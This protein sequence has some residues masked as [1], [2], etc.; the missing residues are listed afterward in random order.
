MIHCVFAVT[1]PDVYIY[2]EN[3]SKNSGRVRS[4]VDGRVVIWAINGQTVVMECRTINNPPKAKVYWIWAPS[5]SSQLGAVTL[6]NGLQSQDPS[7]YKIGRGKQ[8]DSIRLEI[9]TIAM[10][11]V[12][13]GAGVYTCQSSFSGRSDPIK[14]IRTIEVYELPQ[15][16]LYESSYETDSTEND[17]ITL[18][19]KAIGTPKPEIYWRRTSGTSR[20]ISGYGTEVRGS[21]ILFP[22]VKPSD[23]GLYTCNAI[24]K[25]GFTTWEIKLNVKFQPKVFNVPQKD[26]TAGI[27]HQ[28]IGCNAEIQFKIEG[29]PAPELVT[30]TNSKGQTL[31]N[32]DPQNSHITIY[33]L[34][35]ADSTVY[36]SINFQ[37]FTEHDVGDYKCVAINSFGNG[38]NTIKLMTSEKSYPIRT[39]YAVCSAMMIQSFISIISVH[40]LTVYIFAKYVF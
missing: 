25:L 6:N 30:L 36:V 28:K 13:G 29:H 21:E 22:S 23:R 35:A 27:V 5:R 16:V 39:G 26:G 15:I 40:V 7:K 37:P 17:R 34:Q 33:Q 12:V 18:K 14:A 32:N 38:Q 8:A 19:C 4:E 2:E 3:P 1:T 24:N 31:T 20:I 10:G 11:F 9:S